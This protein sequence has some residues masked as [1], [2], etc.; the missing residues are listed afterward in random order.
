MRRLKLGLMAAAMVTAAAHTA[1][2]ASLQVT[3]LL[4]E[5][6]APAATS[7]LTLRN[8]SPRP[9]NAQVRVFRW[10]QANGQD[11]LEATDA[12]VASPPLVKLASRVSY[13]VRVVRTSRQPVT[14]EE[15][16]RL[17]IDE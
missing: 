5:V 14:A 2:A 7:T 6:P 16:Y 4:I 3:P 11:V 1:T 12:V 8:E 13:A 9:A 15:A 10:S 17:V